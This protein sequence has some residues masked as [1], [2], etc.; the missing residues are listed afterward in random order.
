MTIDQ[1]AKQFHL[2]ADTLRYYEKIGLIDK[3]QKD[4]RGYRNYQKE[5]IS[6]IEFIVCMRS[7]GLSIKVLQQYIQ[8]LELG[9]RSIVQRK[10]LLE[11]E[12]RKLEKRIEEM[13]MTLKK[14]EHKIKIYDM[15]I[16]EE[17]K[18]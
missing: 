10:E 17:R 8:L 5:D 18:C 4:K 12:H 11:E 2:T 14:L 1:V 13:Q 9:D 7:A 15:N 6:R 3:V 16:K